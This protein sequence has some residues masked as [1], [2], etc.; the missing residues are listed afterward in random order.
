MKAKVEE[1]ERR[2]QNKEEE[3]ASSRY[4]ESGS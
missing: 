2:G 3:E 4:L 1:G